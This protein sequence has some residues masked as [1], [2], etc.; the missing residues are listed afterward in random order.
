MQSGRYDVIQKYLADYL[1]LLQNKIDH[2]TTQLTAQSVSCPTT[3]QPLEITDHRLREFVRLHHLDLLRTVRYQSSKLKDET[4]EKVLLK[5]LSYYY[6]DAA[7]V[8]PS[9]YPPNEL[10]RRSPHELAQRNH[11]LG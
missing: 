11:S 2:Y 9:P 1:L 7:Q 6:L 3:L 5:E 10:A 8:T 4:R